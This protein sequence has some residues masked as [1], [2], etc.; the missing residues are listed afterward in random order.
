MKN[1]KTLLLIVSI[2]VVVVM[3]VGILSA[4][5]DDKNKD[6]VIIGSTTEL[7]GDFRWPG[8]GGSSAGAAD[9]DINKL[10]TGYSTMDSNRYGAYVWNET[11]VKRHTEAET[12]A[13]TYLITIEINE[14]L[15]MSN[16]EEVKAANYLA[17][18]L[19]M[20][21]DVG[22]EGVDYNTAGQ[23]FV[24]YADFSHYDGTND[25]QL[26]VVKAAVEA[27]ETTPAKDAVMSKTPA[28][29]AFKGLRLL[30]DY[31]FSVEVSSEYYPYYYADTYG[32]ITPYDLKLVL[33]EGVTV[34][35]DG[36]GAYLDGNWYEKA[37]GKFVKAA[38][39]A[40]ARY[41][42]DT[43]AYTG[44]YTISNWDKTSKEATLKLNANFKGTFDK[45][46]P[47]IPT[48][49][50]R[51]VVSATQIN[52]LKSGGVDTTMAL[53]GAEE[54]NA[55]LA[56]VQAGG[57]GENHYDR[58]GYGKIQFDCDFSPTMFTEVRQAVAYCFDRTEFANTFCGGYGSV[59][60][61]PY[62]AN[63][64]AAHT[65]GDT[66]TEALNEYACS[67]DNVKK[68]LVAGGWTYTSTGENKGENWTKGT[69]VD[70]VRY[71]KLS[72]S[73]YGVDDANKTY[74][75][76]TSE[77]VNIKTVKIGEDYFMPLVI[78]WMCTENN[79][80]SAL[81]TTNLKEAQ[82]TKDAGI[83]ITKTESDFNTLLAQI[84]REGDA[85]AGP[86]YGMM[87]L[88][89]GWNSSIYDY[90]FN[91]VDNSNKAEYDAYFG[92]STNKLSDAYDAEF[93]WW[94]EAN[95]GLTYDQAKEKSGGKLGMNYI[96]FAMVYSVKTGN[97]EEYNKWFKEY[98][99]RWNELL[100]DIPLYSNIYYDVYNSNKLEGLETGPFWGAAEELIYQKLK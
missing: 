50:Y 76:V 99:V 18:I 97:T 41:D 95:Q 37:D 72:A 36:N 33:G 5:N 57:F 2:L 45:V 68:A 53:T 67:L 55:A 38:H 51:K 1:K 26:Y 85:F 49:V 90:S 54:V 12:E 27:T 20:S 88:A 56:A 78:N 89:T 17:Y 93:S 69:G 39:L 19:A 11:A 73:E 91:W 30:G 62:S 81:L 42:T 35:D 64:D 75:G 7:G 98:M 86:V 31:K 46:L 100:P 66:L 74:A 25:G 8:V 92:Y 9:Q 94:D 15:T 87:N 52:D 58:A 71:K 79:P 59:V 3:S 14:G 70:I 84:Y 47:T 4:C 21:T 61:A 65:L 43:Y 28:T 82:I 83:L 24:G 44:A 13:G 77:G 29:K 80:V 34:K 32:A 23:S 22:K 16:G 48:I 60:N 96:S 63:F 6:T 10:T 40:A